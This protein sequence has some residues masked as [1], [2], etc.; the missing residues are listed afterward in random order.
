MKLYNSVAPEACFRELE[1]WFKQRLTSSNYP[2]GWHLENCFDNCLSMPVYRFP[3][4]QLSTAGFPPDEVIQTG[5]NFIHNDLE[6]QEACFL[7]SQTQGLTGLTYAFNHANYGMRSR[8]IKRILDH[9]L[10]PEFKAQ[11]DI[12][13][14]ASLLAG[15][16]KYFY[17]IWLKSMADSEINLFIDLPPNIYNIDQ[18]VGI[19]VNVKDFSGYHG[20]LAERLAQDLQR[21]IDLEEEEDELKSGIKF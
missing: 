17:D 14:Q 15:G 13:F 19:T 9:L 12:E 7:V 16:P 2:K 20:K 5:W 21:S 6:G 1:N 4:H 8:D 3:L 11:F 10:A 18:E